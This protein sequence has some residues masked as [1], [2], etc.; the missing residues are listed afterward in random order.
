MQRIHF[1]FTSDTHGHWLN[2]PDDLDHSLLNTT[3]A[4]QTLRQAYLDQGDQVVSLDLGDFIQGSSYATYL[5]QVNHDGKV[6][7]RAMNEIGYDFQLLGNHEF[8]FGKAYRDDI[9]KDLEATFLVSNLVNQSDGQPIIGQPYTIIERGGIKIGII[10]VTTHY[11]PHWEMPANY[12]GIDFLDAYATSKKYVAILRPQVDILVLAYHGGYEKDLT[13]FEALEELTGENQGAKILQEIEGIDLFLTGH[14]HR[15]ICQHVA[16]TL[17][18]Q[19]GYAGE[20]IGHAQ[21]DFEAGQITNMI[22]ELIPTSSYEKSPQQIQTMSPE[23]EQGDHWLN[24]VIGQAPLD[25]VTDNEFYARVYGHPYI[26]LLNN[27]QL[28][29]TG[30]DFSGVALVNDYFAQ[31]SGPI[32]NEVLLKSYPYYNLI[33]TVTMTGQEI[34]D[35][36]NFNLEYFSLDDQGQLR[37]NPD[38][39]DPKPKHYNWDIYSGIQTKVD[40]QAPSGQRVVEIIDEST[41]QPIDRDKTYV[42]AVSQYRAVGGGD[43][44]WFKQEKIKKISQ[45]DIA[46]L[47]K[48]ALSQLSQAEWQAINHNYQHM[49]WT[50]I[51]GLSD[52]PAQKM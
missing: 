29:E 50:G 21:V 14:Q 43:F 18:I 40:M 38:Y 1:L 35:I 2:R 6:I 15:Q 51:A 52:Q 33:A 39:I 11:I 45:I 16:Q 27:I 32:T 12:E 17:T 36:M 47:L 5:S 34:Y 19:P 31:F 48:Q 46:T 13:T 49:V 42:L 44:K 10:G 23:L 22:G 7:A 9:F 30:A 41:Q 4:F 25:Q 3:T 26:E 8:N 37:I 28:Q 20:F 24:E